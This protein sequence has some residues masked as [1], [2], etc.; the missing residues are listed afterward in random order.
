MNCLKVLSVPV[1]LPALWLSLLLRLGSSTFQAEPLLI[2]PFAHACTS[3]VVPLD[4]FSHLA[5]AP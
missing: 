1:T 3:E 4:L 2:L 5:D